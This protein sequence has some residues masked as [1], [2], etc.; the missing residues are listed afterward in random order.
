M[1]TGLR[2]VERS[3]WG[4]S[5]EVQSTLSTNAKGEIIMASPAKKIEPEVAY[6]AVGRIIQA[7]GALFTVASGS[8]EYQA[9]RATSCLIE[10]AEGDCVL[11]SIVPGRGTYIVAVLEREN[12]NARLTVEGDLE[13]RVPN[14]RFVVAARDGID[15][16]STGNVGVVADAFKLTTRTADVV[17][18]HLGLIGTTVQAQVQKA[19]LVAET[20]DQAADRLTQ[21][22]K[23]AYRF[24]SEIEQVRAHRIDVAAEKTFNLH[25]QNAVVTAEELVK[26]DGGQIHLG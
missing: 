6:Q 16:V 7:Q 2:R 25:A 12:E 3:S 5:N 23:R 14:G 21:R 18:E 10:P 19:K 15:L 17:L 1:A 22:I 8:A 13:L 9:R 4:P 20:I 26:V 11:F 24:V